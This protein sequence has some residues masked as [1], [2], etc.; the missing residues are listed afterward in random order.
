M[1]LPL[2]SSSF[3]P[4]S[5]SSL[6]SSLPLPLSLPLLTLLLSVS[7]SLLSSLYFT[8]WKC[9]IK[10][11]LPDGIFGCFGAEPDVGFS[12]TG[13]PF[14]VLA[15]FFSESA[16]FDL[17][18][19]SPETVLSFVSAFNSTCLAFVKFVTTFFVGFN[20]SS[21][22]KEEITFPALTCG[23]GFVGTI[24]SV[25]FKIEV[26]TC[27][28]GGGPDFTFCSFGGVGKDLL[29]SATETILGDEWSA[30]D[31]LVIALLSFFFADKLFCWVW[32]LL[33]SPCSDW[34]DC[35]WKFELFF[36]EFR[37]GCNL[38][39]DLVSVFSEM[40]L[41]AIVLSML[42]SF[43][44]SLWCTNTSLVLISLSLSLPSS[45]QLLNFLPS[46]GIISKS[47]LSPRSSMLFP[48]WLPWLLQC[49]SPLLELL[50]VGLAWRTKLCIDWGLVG[51]G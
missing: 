45:L 41:V 49:D 1:S 46:R 32:T 30:S 2:L 21:L 13:K 43:V 36:S 44:L 47:W 34:S 6:S 15:N 4:S 8:S 14:E 17:L 50:V 33:F 24:P 38:F 10:G 7:S 11:G 19:T 35:F 25:L 48:S 51:G 42:A 23:S 29:G 16:L 3:S 39:P 22:S 28:R 20:I 40:L 9:A 5:P 31:F 12:T 18:C 37:S 27:S 26:G